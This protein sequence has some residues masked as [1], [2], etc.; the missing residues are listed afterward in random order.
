MQSVTKSSVDAAQS[1]HTQEMRK[2]VASIVFGAYEFDIY[3]DLLLVS[4]SLCLTYNTASSIVFIAVVF[5]T[6]N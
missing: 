1:T 4:A 6:V 5:R 3:I 2:L